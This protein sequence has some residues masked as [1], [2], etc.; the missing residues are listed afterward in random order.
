MMRNLDVIE[1]EKAEREANAAAF[2]MEVQ[3]GESKPQDDTQPEENGES[4][5]MFT[6]EEVNH[7]V[8]ERL[9][10][11]RAKQISSQ[12]FQDLEARENRLKCREYLLSH[13]YDISAHVSEEMDR[14]LN[15]LKPESFED[16]RDRLDEIEALGSGKAT[17]TV[18]STLSGI[19]GL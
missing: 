5:R 11:E 17:A 7:I 12:E 18:N 16:F 6:Q 9:A 3:A 14:L 4:G 10:R 2:P 8:S 15:L 13:Y 1:Q 19:F